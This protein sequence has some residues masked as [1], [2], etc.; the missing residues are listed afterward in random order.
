MDT[1]DAKL[2]LL[3]A[4][5]EE[6]HI[7]VE[8]LEALI[9]RKKSRADHKTTGMISLTECERNMNAVGRENEGS[10]ILELE[11]GVRTKMKGRKWALSITRDESPACKRVKIDA[12]VEDDGAATSGALVAEVGKVHHREILSDQ[13]QDTRSKEHADNLSA[14]TSNATALDDMLA[15]LISPVHSEAL[16]P[17]ETTE[18]AEVKG[19]YAEECTELDL[20]RLHLDARDI[21]ISDVAN[22]PF[23]VGVTERDKGQ[24]QA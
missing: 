16:Q 2:T 14:K 24:E 18:M 3:A 10:D 6:A 20:I 15:K 21:C 12:G 8:V 23:A 13:V 17:P 22:R 7:D 4:F 19:D 9:E 1:F 5:V 11:H